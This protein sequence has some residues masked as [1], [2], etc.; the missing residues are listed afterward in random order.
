MP[1]PAYVPMQTPMSPPA[2]AFAPR[3][4]PTPAVPA[5]TSPRA[6]GGAQGA[7]A[8]ALRQPLARAKAPDE[9]APAR[10]APL[11]MP[12]PEQ[13][14]VVVRTAADSPNWSAL[15]ARMNELGIV[16]FHMDTL[17]DGRHRF[18]CWL[19]QGQPGATQRIEALAATE[20]EAARAGLER[21]AQ[22]RTSP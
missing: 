11:V 12:S 14:G 13:L 22:S 6:R 5:S 7:A 10:P 19:P 20:I 15:H 9:P 17:P 16:S 21:A 18:T 2:P 3:N 1:S 8:P 4:N